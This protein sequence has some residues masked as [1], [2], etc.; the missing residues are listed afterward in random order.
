M[1]I[2]PLMG[3]IEYFQTSI[4]QTL[5]ICEEGVYRERTLTLAGNISTQVGSLP[6]AFSR[7]YSGIA[8]SHSSSPDCFEDDL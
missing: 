6:D 4:P 5:V 1:T 2:I 7:P 3:S 8:S